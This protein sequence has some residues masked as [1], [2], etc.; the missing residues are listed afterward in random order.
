M[1][2]KPRN[3][4]CLRFHPRIRWAFLIL[5]QSSDFSSFGLR[6]NLEVLRWQPEY[7]LAM[8]RP[9]SI[10][11]RQNFVLMMTVSWIWVIKSEKSQMR[12]ICIL[13]G[14][15]THLEWIESIMNWKTVIF[16]LPWLVTAISF[17]LTLVTNLKPCL[18]ITLFILLPWP[19][20]VLGEHLSWYQLAITYAKCRDTEIEI[21]W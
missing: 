21:P 1:S 13:P 10:I 8:E 15:T 19:K 14:E 2:W 20:F 7:L 6:L 17:I 4:I 18:I 16:Y 9:H 3:E 12:W 11:L 5:S